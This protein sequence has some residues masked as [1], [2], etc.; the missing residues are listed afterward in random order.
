MF[1]FMRT[2]DG[3]R[4]LPLLDTVTG[5]V[6][7]EYS[8]FPL[9]PLLFVFPVVPMIKKRLRSLQHGETILA[10]AGILLPVLLLAMSLV[11]LLGQ[12]YNPF[13]YFRF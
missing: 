13:I 8:F 11:F 3:V 1:G 2:A 12:S 6:L 4:A 5:N 10:V 7:K 9:I